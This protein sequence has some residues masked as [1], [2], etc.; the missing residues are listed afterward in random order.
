MP[1]RRRKPTKT[2]DVRRRSITPFSSGSPVHAVRWKAG[3]WNAIYDLVQLHGY[4]HKAKANHVAEVAVKWGLAF[5]SSLSQTMQ[6]RILGIERELTIDERQRLRSELEQKLSSEADILRLDDKLGFALPHVMKDVLKRQKE[7]T[8]V[9]MSR[10][11][12]QA[13]SQSQ[14]EP[15]QS[16]RQTVRSE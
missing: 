6:K 2:P 11:I 15:G 1:R 3:T 14:S 8:G 16:V 10:Q 12:R 9:S 4:N 5:I 7:R 13:L